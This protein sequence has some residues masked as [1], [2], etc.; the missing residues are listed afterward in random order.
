M[1]TYTLFNK[2]I[3][4]STKTRQQTI[5]T[6][7]EV[8]LSTLARNSNERILAAAEGEPSRHGNANIYLIDATQN[9]LINK[10]TFFRQGIQSMAFSNCGRFLIAASVP[11]EGILAIIDVNSGMVCEG[12]TVML[13]DQSVNKVV[14]N[15]H[16][17]R[18][19]DFI[20]VGQRGN[21]VIWKYDYEA[22]QTLNIEPDMNQDLQNTDFT[23]ATFTPKLPAPFNCE[24]I[25]IGTADGAIA[26]V[27]PNPSDGDRKFEW[28]EHGKKEFLLSE[29]I[30]SIIHKQSKVV[31]SGSR[32]TMLRYD[33]KLARVLPDDPDMISKIK[34]EDQVTA[35]QMDDQNNEGVIG[36]SAGT[37]K[38]I[39]FSDEQS[40][41]V[42]LVTK[43]SP[44]MD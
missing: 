39:A 3:I 41:T 24:L 42:K 14:V 17:D 34:S 31:I 38:Y 29:S 37:I 26:A 7:S 22:Q 13:K 27:N 11:D 28:L 43:V 10:I 32:G 12:G 21:F 8:R 4:E 23:C 16:S 9:K 1:I 15:P 33:D 36:T 18:D 2:I 6:E 35:T 20:T 19:V 40:Q 5:M 44:Y 30:S 25:M